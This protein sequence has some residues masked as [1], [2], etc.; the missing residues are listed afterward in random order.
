MCGLCL[1][2]LRDLG[3]KMPTLV[4]SED[5]G[6]FS[7]APHSETV[8]PM[9]SKW[10][11][12]IFFEFSPRKLGKISNLTSIF[13]RWVGSTTNQSRGWHGLIWGFPGLDGTVPGSPRCFPMDYRDKTTT[14][15]MECLPRC[16]CSCTSLSADFKHHG[17]SR[18]FNVSYIYI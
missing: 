6:W 12:Q 16:N 5:V 10:C 7:W 18:F 14:G 15:F 1:L 9:L 8:K 4:A 13:F 17:F 2:L 3:V 11:F